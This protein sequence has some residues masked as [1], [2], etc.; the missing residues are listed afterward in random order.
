VK[1][2]FLLRHAKAN[3]DTPGIDDINRRLA[4][5]GREDAVRMGRFMREE[6]RIPALVLCSTAVRTQESLALL[7]PELGAHPLVQYRAD[8]Y[9]ARPEII[10]ASIRHARE[11]AGSLMVVGHNPGIEECAQGLAREPV[12]RKLRKRYQL[13]SDKFPTGS[14]AV[15]DFDVS[16]W[17]AIGPGGGELELFVRPK[18]LRLVEE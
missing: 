8:L 1:R 2:L 18:D 5:R 14:L 4:E 10:L 15:I 13:M 6:D 9:L 17:S 12:D 16:Q 3:R 11:T 7:L